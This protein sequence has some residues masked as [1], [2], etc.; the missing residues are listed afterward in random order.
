MA[1]RGMYKEILAKRVQIGVCRRGVQADLSSM[2]FY[3]D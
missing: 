1:D 3:R 2:L